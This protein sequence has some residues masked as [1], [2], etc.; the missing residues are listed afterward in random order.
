MP[1][2]IASPVQILFNITL[3]KTCMLHRLWTWTLILLQ[4]ESHVLKY[5]CL[6]DFYGQLYV[7]C[8]KKCF[9]T[10]NKPHHAA[11]VCTMQLQPLQNICICQCFTL[12][13]LSLIRCCQPIKCF[14][15]GYVIP[16]GDL[17][18]SLL[19]RLLVVKVPFQ[20]ENNFLCY[21]YCL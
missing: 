12:W 15:T 5:L 16:C 11:F 4:V 6:T 3:T 8:C 1:S 17:V 19:T 7:F 14:T 10:N 20:S 18:V 13:C 2:T 21:Q 9:S